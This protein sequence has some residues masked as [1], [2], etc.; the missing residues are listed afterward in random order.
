MQNQPENA[1]WVD[2]GKDFYAAVTWANYRTATGNKLWLGW[3]N[4]WQYAQK[5]PTFP[6][7]G[8]MSLVRELQLKSTNEGIKLV[9]IPVEALTAL[10]IEGQSW[11]NVPI[12]KLNA[13]LKR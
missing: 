13:E 5:L 1:H 7:R 2:Y 4:N 11:H 6:W 8:S 12:A 3:M 10:R 9:Q